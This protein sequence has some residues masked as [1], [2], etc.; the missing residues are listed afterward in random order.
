MVEIL[1]LEIP[2]AEISI[3]KNEVNN[4]EGPAFGFNNFGNRRG[5][6]PYS[7]NSE[8]GF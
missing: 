6:S 7:G 2:T 1:V 8:F 3:L 4:N 5:G